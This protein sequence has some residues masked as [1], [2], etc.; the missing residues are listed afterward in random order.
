MAA[1]E[2][3]FADDLQCQVEEL[4]L[5]RRI[6]G[7]ITASEQQALFRKHGSHIGGNRKNRANRQ[8]EYEKWR[9][10][11]SLEHLVASTRAAL[12]E[13]LVAKVKREPGDAI[14]LWSLGRLGARIPLYGPRHAVVAPALAAAWL[15]AL[16]D[17]GTFTPAMASAIVQLARRTD[18][19]SRDLD[20]VIR[21]R[22]ISC[23]MASGIA[24][25][26]TRL[27]SNCVL[28]APS[29]SVRSFGESL[30]PG[31]Q[32][33]SSANCLLSVPALSQR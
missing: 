3:A 5:L 13:D 12:G 24:E 19:G 25:E 16:L 11:A 29:D 6:A 9:L 27:L 28:P 2:L 7:G 23:L 32:V 1:N 21:E 18:D 10:V 17:L 4:V 33:V 20:Q 15:E 22:A 30:P 14:W 26:T 8:L 31:L